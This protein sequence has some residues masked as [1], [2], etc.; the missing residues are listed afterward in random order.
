MNIVYVQLSAL[1]LTL[2]G[3]LG[4]P[5][6]AGPG[7]DHGESTPA[8]PTSAFPRF[9]ASSDDFDLVGV[10]QGHRLTVY[11]DHAPD[12]RP[13]ENGQLTL[14]VA[15]QALP[16]TPQEA[17]TFVADWPENLESGEVA[18]TAVIQVYTQSDLLVAELDLHNEE[19]A[20][21]AEQKTPS[22]NTTLPWVMAAV[23]ILLAGAGLGNTFYSRRQTA[24][25]AKA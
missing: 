13:V 20:H 5:A 6:W 18:I 11:L 12:N 10:L 23:G 21:T 1:L 8:A 4:N 17:G 3:L 7:H 9:T 22:N 19:E 16:L 15:G 2:S 25:G 24:K 14:E